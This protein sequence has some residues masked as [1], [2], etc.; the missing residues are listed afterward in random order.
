MT[1]RVSFF[2]AAL[3]VGCGDKD[4]ADTAWDMPACTPDSGVICAW[5]GTGDAAYDGG[6]RHRLNSYFYYPMDVEFSPHGRPVIADWNNHKLRLVEEDDTLTTIMGTDF[7]G[8][9]P[10]DLG[11]LTAPGADGTT[12]NLNHPTDHEYYSNGVLLS[13]SWHTHKL[14]TWDPATGLVMV[15]L[16]SSPGFAGEDDAPASE[17]KLNQPKAVTIDSQ[18]NA[19][20][21]DMRNER[22]RLLTYQETVRTIAGN[23]EKDYCGD[24]GPAT[25]ACLN[26][27][28]SE[29]PEPG[30][31][32][33]LSADE[34]TLYIADTEN[35]VLRAV[36]LDTG[37]IS[38]VVGTGTAGFA[39]DGGPGLSAQL[40]FP[41]DIEV[42][43]DG[44]IF[45]ADEGNN[46]VRV[47]D[48]SADSIETYAG[49]GE[50]ASEGDD[51][52]ALDASFNRPF[53]VEVDSDGAVYVADTFAHRIRVIY[54]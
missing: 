17:A 5:A 36:D 20:F 38:T 25:E 48:P 24:G 35:H 15:V 49:N 47:W 7:L 27:P 32:V 13:A 8:D 21:V 33:A 30:G 41:R 53:G 31:S 40:S 18:G 43:P 19:Y 23:G 29:N 28:K 50:L 52:P 2:A 4:T 10:P 37:L 26:F 34:R 11:D 1:H 46:R 51:G 22:V 45:I 42:G 9:G 6:G 44:R 16:G 12:V 39:G 54:P 3:L 14:R